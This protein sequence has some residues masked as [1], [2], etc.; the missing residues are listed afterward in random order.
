MNPEALTP[1][2]Q[3]DEEKVREIFLWLNDYAKAE[4]SEHKGKISDK[5]LWGIDRVLKD[6]KQQ[7]ENLQDGIENVDFRLS[8]R[9]LTWIRNHQP[10]FAETA[11]EYLA[12]IKNI[13]AK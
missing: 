4:R 12:T 9:V 8:I 10:N 13:Q 3:S 1:P 11:E 2:E 7:I 6:I 5:D